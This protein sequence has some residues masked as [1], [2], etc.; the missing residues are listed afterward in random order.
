MSPP[1]PLL[2]P[3]SHRS[4]TSYKLSKLPDSALPNMAPAQGRR[5]PRVVQFDEHDSVS[6]EGDEDASFK[7]KEEEE[8]ARTML[9]QL[10]S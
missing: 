6:L 8:F 10:V 7:W 1:G 2:L 3:S 9:K 5:P 4:A